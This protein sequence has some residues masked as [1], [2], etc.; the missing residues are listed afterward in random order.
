MGAGAAGIAAARRMAAAGRRFVLV[1]A[2]DHVGGRCITDTR[3]FGVPFDRGAHLIHVP[4][5]NPLI[6]AVPRG[7]VEIYPAPSG[8]K[9]RIGRRN[10]R[11]GEL[12]D[13]IAARVRASRAIGEV[14]RKA[15]V[16][17][18]QGLPRDLGEWHSAVEFALGP[19][20]CGKDLSE[21]SAVDFT[22]M[23][24]RDIGSYCRQGFGTLLAKLAE[25]VPVQLNSPVEA[26]D[27]GNRN[28]R[29]EVKTPKG[30]IVARFGIV[31]VSTEVLNAGKIRFESERPLRQLEAAAR[32]KLGSFDHIALELPGNPL[33]LQRDELMFEKSSS[34]RTGAIL[35]NVSGSSLT[36]VEVAG[37]FGRELSAQGEKAMTDAAIEWL[38]GLFGTDV[39][40]AVKRT[41]VT[42]WNADPWT[43]GAV[44]SAS[45]GAQGA[46]RQL[47]EPM[48]DRLFFAG[49]ATHET[50][51]GTV[52]GAWETGERAA[53]GVLRRL[54]VLKAPEEPR[55]QP[56]QRPS[57]RRS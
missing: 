54:G 55:P 12:E 30:T 8:Q 48:R 39:R 13:F 22:R 4:D 11:E 1:E 40:K 7:S 14:S 46:R 45:P 31:T 50:M 3:T 21:I 43:L 38:T 6:K 51:W 32:L 53:E 15:D 2:T 33:G 5:L 19:Y 9:I 52:G 44:S 47:A 57:R 56:Q 16:A 18:A 49:E 41:A 10:A 25:G 34:T 27:T 35:A 20:N 36:I 23:A 29:V 28:N 37:R 17:A 26:I 24:E 42:Q